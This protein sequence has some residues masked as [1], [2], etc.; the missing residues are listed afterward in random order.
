MIVYNIFGIFYGLFR[1][2]RA[3]VKGRSHMD[4]I[5]QLLTLCYGK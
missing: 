1:A 2:K 5:N 3:V 4:V